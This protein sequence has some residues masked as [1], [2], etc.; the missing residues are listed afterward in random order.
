M[1]EGCEDH[2]PG[3]PWSTELLP[4]HQGLAVAGPSSGRVH[5]EIQGDPQ[6]ACG[7][8]EEGRLW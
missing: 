4:V 7:L 5:W 3:A 2:W 1:E 8:G 6:A